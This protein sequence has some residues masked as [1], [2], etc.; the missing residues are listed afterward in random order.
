MR[1]RSRRSAA[2]LVAIALLPGCALP[3]ARLP[4]SSWTAEPE[5]GKALVFILYAGSGW[6]GTFATVFIEEP[7][8]E[9][10]YLGTLYNKTHLTLQLDPGSYLLAVVGDTV[11]LM[12]VTVEAGR[13][14]HGVVA[15][16]LAPSGGFGPSY[17]HY[18]FQPMNDP[19]DA[20]LYEWIA[21][22]AEVEPTEKGRQDGEAHRRRLSEMKP[23]YKPR[24]EAKDSPQH[25]H[26]PTPHRSAATD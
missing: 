17:G 2:A 18:R 5:P 15:A 25:L 10:R 26:V 23:R 11:D 21:A 3:F 14:Y 4:E 19:R 16:Y 8:G 24:W 9:D 7:S 20:R 1:I 22:S 6:G 13:T 12:Q